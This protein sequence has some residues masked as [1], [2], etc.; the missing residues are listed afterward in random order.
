MKIFVTGAS[1]Y[2]G[3]SVGARLVEAGHEVR[4]LVRTSAKLD[5]VRRTGI[6]PVEGTLDDAALL[7]QEARAADAVINA[8]SSD[9]RASIDALVAALAGSDKAF[10][11]TSG[12]SIVADEALGE[13]SERIFDE[14]T[15]FTPPPERAARVALDRFLLAAPGI[16]SVVLCNSLI[17]GASLGVPTESV[18]VPLLASE[19]RRVGHGRHIGRGLNTWSTVHIA[20]LA[21][22]YLLALERAPAGTFCFVE[23]GEATFRAMAG[24]VAERLGLGAPE[25]WP[26]EEAIAELGRSKAVF[27]MGSNSRVR[28]I[29]ARELLGWTPKQGSVVDWIKSE[30]PLA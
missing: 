12:T 2:I 20:D 18:Q 28:G 30:L 13:P 23:H 29:R 4:G 14:T 9:H 7:A 5:A 1:G 16:R 24:A 25:P 15:P 17:Y 19:A 22:L 21:D 27:T 11:H 6:T 10:L 8:A 26:P 3:S